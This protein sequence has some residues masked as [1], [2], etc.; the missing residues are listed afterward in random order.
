MA[1]IVKLWDEVDLLVKLK[2]DTLI[3][4]QHCH[5]IP[6]VKKLVEAHDIL[7][8]SLEIIQKFPV[9]PPEPA[10]C[11]EAALLHLDRLIKEVSIYYPQD[12]P[13]PKFE[14]YGMK[15]KTL[16]RIFNLPKGGF[17]GEC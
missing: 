1:R 15:I 7:D 10:T 14:I 5:S 2:T 6:P 9:Q 8:L 12:I 13:Q 16:L 4:I 17:Y 11:D 3:I